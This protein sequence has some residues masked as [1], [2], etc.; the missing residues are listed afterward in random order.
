MH[1][2]ARQESIVRPIIEKYN[3]ENNTEHTTQKNYTLLF[4]ME[5]V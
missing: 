1:K 2:D 5:S 4:D 3:V